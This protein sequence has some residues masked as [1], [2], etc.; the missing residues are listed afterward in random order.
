MRDT[1]VSSYD[2]SEQRNEIPSS[3][4]GGKF[5]TQLSDCRYIEYIGV[6]AVSEFIAFLFR[7]KFFITSLSYKRMRNCNGNF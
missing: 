1:S 3:T 4:D 7:H 6:H 5:F 2:I